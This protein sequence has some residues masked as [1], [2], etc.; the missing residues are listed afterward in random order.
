MWAGARTDSCRVDRL[1]PFE[2]WCLSQPLV[3]PQMDPNRDSVLLRMDM[4]GPSRPADCFDGVVAF[5]VAVE[6]M[7]AAS[8]ERDIP[9]AMIAGTRS[10]F[11][12]LDDADREGLLFVAAGA[13]DLLYRYL[14]QLTIMDRY[15]RAYCSLVVRSLR[16]VSAAPLSAMQ[17]LDNAHREDR[18]DS[19]GELWALRHRHHYPSRM[20]AGGEVGA[21]QISAR[22]L[23]KSVGETTIAVV[24]SGRIGH[25]CQRHNVSTR[26][27]VLTSEISPDDPRLSSSIFR[28]RGRSSQKHHP[29]A[30]NRRAGR[31]SSI[32]RS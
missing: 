30:L 24:G 15:T 25:L 4:R 26:D 8:D 1:H 29:T 7:R 23:Q 31:S 20:S 5:P 16:T 27:S 18:L 9:K 28:G 13:Q 3:L 12:V 19:D 6:K 11:Q 22:R 32:S 17:I 21:R 2:H 10:A 14:M